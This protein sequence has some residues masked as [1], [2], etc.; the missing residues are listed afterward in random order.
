MTILGVSLRAIAD[1]LGSDV[2]T[3]AWVVTAPMLAQAVSAQ[4]LG[5]LG[6][7]PG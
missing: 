1:D 4:L 3:I 7:M 6:G 5:K 2:T